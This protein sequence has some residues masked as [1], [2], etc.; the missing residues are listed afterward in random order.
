MAGLS[1]PR[2]FK[3]VLSFSTGLFET[4]DNITVCPVCSR[5]YQVGGDHIPR[6]LPCFCTVCEGCITGK[7]SK[8]TNLE[9]PQCGTEHTAQNGIKNIQENK[10]IISYMKKMIER[11]PMKKTEIKTEDW[12]KEC[13]MHGKVQSVYCNESECQTPICVMCLKD[14]HKGHDFCD[15]QEVAE[16]RSAAFLEDVQSLKETLQKKKDELLASL[17]LVVQNCEQC[18]LEINNV[19]ADLKSEIDRK[20]ASLVYNIAEHKKKIDARVNKVIVNIDEKL[21]IVNNFEVIANTA[22]I[23]EVKPDKLEELKNTRTQIQSRYSAT[24]NYPALTYKKCGDMSK[25]LSSLCGKLTLGTTQISSEMIRNLVKCVSQETD[26]NGNDKVVKGEENAAPTVTAKQDDNKMTE[27]PCVENI[28][29][30]KDN[31]SSGRRTE[32]IT[33]GETLKKINCVVTGV[34]PFKDPTARATKSLSSTITAKPE[35]VKGRVNIQPTVSDI[36]CMQAVNNINASSLTQPKDDGVRNKDGA[37][38]GITL[39]Q[40]AEKIVRRTQPAGKM[41]RQPAEDGASVLNQPATNFTKIIQ[42]LVNGEAKILLKENNTP[43]D[44]PVVDKAKTFE[45]AVDKI[46][47]TKSEDPKGR[48]NT[49]S[50]LGDTRTS[51]SRLCGKRAVVGDH[52]HPVAKRARLVSATGGDS[53]ANYHETWQGES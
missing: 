22:T 17:K 36:Q 23:F 18:T 45:P 21:D 32:E 4:M 14:D 7:L 28:P 24:T 30:G 16:K 46:K 25:Y 47:P 39:T 13:K 48:T 53:Q 5:N 6:I 31:D 29:I 51:R 38:N 8:G 37:C 19:K 40:P 52:T 15:L 12:G 27:C 2:F 34:G 50:R 49:A 41:N 10:Y 26:C 42:P 33:N 44:P 11:S 43:F 3:F 35:E 20:A 9:C 1:K